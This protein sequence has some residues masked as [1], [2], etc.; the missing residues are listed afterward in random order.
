MVRRME[1]DMEAEVAYRPIEIWLKQ[2]RKTT[3]DFNRLSRSP[4]DI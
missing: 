1:K 4:D 2:L 3:K